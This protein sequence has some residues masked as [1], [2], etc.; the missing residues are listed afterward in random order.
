MY[1]AIHI[2]MRHLLWARE[3][4]AYLEAYEEIPE[5][6]I[7]AVYA[8][9]VDEPSQLIRDPDSVLGIYYSSYHSRCQAACFEDLTYAQ[10]ALWVA[11]C[12]AQVSD[13]ESESEEDSPTLEM[14]LESDVYHRTFRMQKQ[15]WK[16]LSD[17]LNADHTDY[18]KEHKRVYLQKRAHHQEMLLFLI[19]QR[20]DGLKQ[21]ERLEKVLR[22]WIGPLYFVP[23]D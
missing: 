7:D 9:K 12:E 2:R 4:S 17:W 13:M 8:A 10:E 11:K 14:R 1:D 19:K 18:K 5:V 22:G 15:A 3:S 23:N 6:D 16:M 20:A 21:K